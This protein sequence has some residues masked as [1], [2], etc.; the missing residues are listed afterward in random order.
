MRKAGL[1]AVGAAA[2]MV[3][4]AGGAAAQCRDNVGGAAFLVPFATG[5][6]ISSIITTIGAVNS[7]SLAQ[8]SAFVGSPS[9]PKPDQ[10][11]GGVW[12]RGI[13]GEVETKANTHVDVAP[14]IFG[15]PTTVDCRTTTK[16]EFVGTQVGFDIG[17]YNFAGGG[18]MYWGATAGYFEASAKDKTPGQGTFNGDWQ[19]PFAGLYAGINS[20]NFAAD[21]QFRGDFYQGRLTDPQQAIF[22][23]E[24]DARSHSFLWNASYRYD[25]A[26]NW[27][28]EP[29]IGGVWSK[30][31]VDPLNVTGLLIA[32]TAR[33]QDIES[34]T[35]R[36]SVRVG[37]TI[38]TDKMAWLPFVT[39]SVFHEFAGNVRTDV[40]Q[41]GIPLATSTTSRV[42]TYGH[43][44]LG[45]A[46]LVLNTGWLGYARVDYRAG[47]NVEG[48]SVNAGLRYQLQPPKD[49]AVSLKDGHRDHDTYRGSYDWTG[50]YAGV[51]AGAVVAYHDY[52][53]AFGHRDLRSSGYLA[54]V[55][56]GYNRQFG[57]M[58]LGVEA[59]VATSN[60]EGGRDCP[61]ANL[62]GNF[63]TC[64]V[65]L[66]NLAILGGRVGYVHERALVY[67]KGGWAVGEAMG[68]NT[69]NGVPVVAPDPNVN[70]ETKT[71]S[72]WALG[73][74]V[75]FA[76]TDRFSAKAEYMHFDLGSAIFNVYNG[77]PA[78]IHVTGDTVRVGLNYHFGK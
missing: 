31:I 68:N 58:L 6:A 27:F 21:A 71:L 55:Q 16:Q 4:G 77:F 70:S 62:I 57:H 22:G 7:S 60:A 67:V 28:I 19:I 47:D 75:E 50:V 36:A 2:V 33:I 41:A 25:V 59:D 35:G 43:L 12:V 30:A 52:N 45:I 61:G 76:L 23:Q 44:G 38:V 65:A 10:Q 13:A 48:I 20:G 56:A 53:D 78:D 26:K 39:A 17:R 42:G 63:Y 74:G 46:G 64:G 14:F 54:G 9:D 49:M 3:A 24:H 29:S 66:N 1:G 69:N 34:L 72:G 51:N 40:D 8:S 32:G 11:G 73:A 15:G 5:S 18:N 37:T